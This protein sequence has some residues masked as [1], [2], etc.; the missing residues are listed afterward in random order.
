M[1]GTDL[2]DHA[3]KRNRGRFQFSLKT[4]LC[5]VT[6]FAVLLSAWTS[7]DSLP[8]TFRRDGN[9]F[10]HG[11]G[12]DR[13]FYSTGELQIEDRYDRGLMT[14]STW[15]RRDGSEIA[16][17]TYTKEKGGVSYYLG[18]TGKIWCKT[19][20]KYS[21]ARGGYVADGEAEYYNPD[22]S[23]SRKSIFRDGVEVSAAK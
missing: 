21:Q 18:E 4:L 1:S 13:H 17:C 10:P 9:G 19:P 15:Y 11:T 8:G 16:S 5:V 23:I 20:Y 14:S 12:V 2:Q 22:G 6:L 7:W 3:P